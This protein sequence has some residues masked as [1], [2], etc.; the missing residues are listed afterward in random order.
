M[1]RIVTLTFVLIIMGHLSASSQ[2][3]QGIIAPGAKVQML[4]DGFSFT[5]GPASDKSGNVYFTDQPNDRIW[6][7]KTD[8]ELNLFMEGTGRANGMY[9]DINGDL[10]SCSDMENELWSISM[11]GKHK[12]LVTDFDRKKLN[13][14]NDVWVAP[15][16]GLYFTDPLYK[17]D[18]WTRDPKMQQDGEHVYYMNPQRDKVIRVD[19]TYVKPNGLVGTSDGKKLYVADIGDNKTYEYDI[20][21]DGTLANRKLFA[22][23]GSDGMTIDERGNIYLTGKGVTVFNPSGEQIEHIPINAGWTA[24]ICFG[25]KDHKTLFITASEYLYSLEMSVKGQ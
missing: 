2:E 6:L 4:A 7:W 15:N 22:S 21:S 12:V 3:H 18:Y 14:P 5:E 13:G 11:D 16:G 23:M 25:G 1:N 24:N 19:E 17:R 20:Q 8:G 9:F 10:L